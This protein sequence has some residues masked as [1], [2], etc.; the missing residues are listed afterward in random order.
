MATTTKETAERFEGI[1]L[2][3]A[4]RGLVR[5]LLAP[6]LARQLREQLGA[7]EVPYLRIEEDASAPQLWSVWH[8]DDILGAGDSLVHALSDAIG[9]VI[10]SER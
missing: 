6:A 8:H 5:E 7:N 3:R 10:A 9:S 1:R 2:Y 4:S